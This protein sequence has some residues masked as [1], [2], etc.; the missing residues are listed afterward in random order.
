[1]AK[2]QQTVDSQLVRVMRDG[3]R[4]ADETDAGQAVAD[5]KLA[6]GLIRYG[7][8]TETPEALVVASQILIRIGLFV[9]MCVEKL[10]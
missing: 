3:A 9:Y 4:L 1:M 2:N 5:R 8:R 6:E 10:S 7:Q